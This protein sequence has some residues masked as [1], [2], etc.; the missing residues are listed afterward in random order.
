VDDPPAGRG[1]KE[2]IQLVA[3]YPIHVAVYR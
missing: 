1:N 2:D 3:S